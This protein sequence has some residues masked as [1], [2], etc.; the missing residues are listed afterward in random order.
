MQKLFNYSFFL[1]LDK[2][3][4]FLLPLLIL[5]LTDD[6]SLYASVEAAIAVSILLVPLLDLGLKYYVSYCYRQEGNKCLDRFDRLLIILSLVSIT[7]SI[8]LLIFSKLFFIV[9]LGI[10][11][12]VHIN[13]YQYCQIRGRLTD[14]LIPPVRLNVVSTALS[15]FLLIAAYHSEANGNVLLF[16]LF[17]VPPFLFLINNFRS[18]S[19][20]AL[21][22]FYPVNDD[23]DD[24]G[25]DENDVDNDNDVKNFLSKCIRFSG[26]AI[27]NTLIVV[28]FANV[29]KL[30]I[31]AKFG[32]ED[33]V[34]YAFA[35]RLALL[36]QVFHM[37]ISGYTFKFFL[38]SS[39]F[40]KMLKIFLMFA[41]SLI[42][43]TLFLAIFIDIVS[44]I[45]S[46]DLLKFDLLTAVVFA[47]T[48]FW[49]LASF[50]E[51]VYIRIDK[52]ELM[53][54]NSCVFLGSYCLF[55]FIF[56]IVNPLSAAVGLLVSAVCMFISN[57]AL[58][59]VNR[60][61]IFGGLSDS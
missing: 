52:T 36:I 12:S 20:A 17:I 30:V 45:V 19:P 15:V 5:F 41:L 14:N 57:V 60:S 25:D 38:M 35:F 10:L 47:Y 26:P 8:P 46:Y 37:V 7:I 44:G 33:L 4:A 16:S 59:F 55:Y 58:I 50:F 9:F 42:A 54:V 21:F 2:G 13:L 31:F 1:F 39:D 3:L 23:D 29:L 48:L 51:F 49:C 27:V 18:L 28:G 24:D 43:I 11:K 61:L 40:V 22:T 56:G 53:L 6:R 32:E 34:E